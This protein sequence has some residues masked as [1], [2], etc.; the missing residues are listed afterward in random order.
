MRPQK[1][2]PICVEAHLGT[3]VAEVQSFGISSSYQG[4]LKREGGAGPAEGIYLHMG[5]RA[6]S[7]PSSRP[8]KTPYELRPYEDQLYLSK[9]DGLLLPVRVVERP[10]FYQ[11]STDDGIPYWKIALL[12][13]ENCLASTVFQMC[14]NWSAEKRCKFCGIELSLRKGLTIPQKTPD[15]LAQVARDASKLD[16]VTHVVLT[17]GTQ[18]HTKEEILHLSRCVSAIKGVVKLPIH[19]QC[20]PVERALLEVLKEAGAD[21]IGI[22]VESFD[23]KVLRRMAP[24]KASIGLS[25]FERS[26]K[27]AVEI[28]GPNQVS[29]F[30]ILGLGEK[31]TSVYRAVNLLGSMGVFPYLVPFRPIPGSILEAWPLPDAQ[32]CIEM[33]RMSAE[34]LSKKG[35]SSSQSLA[36][37]VRCG[38]CSGMKDFEEPKTDLTCRLTC[39]GKELQ[40][41]FK[42]REEVFVREQCMFKDTDRDDYDGQAHHLIVK[43]NGR[44]VGTVRIF[45]KDP[46]QRLWMGGR[47]AVL[48]E[49]RNMGVGEL[50]VKEAV[51][52][53]KL[54]GARRFL[55]YIQIQNVA[56][57]E[58]LGW[59]RVG[60]PFIHRDR[61]HQLMEAS[62]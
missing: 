50:L 61:P 10:K 33:Y 31:P 18:V 12:H 47:L 24:S 11:M 25:T 49:Y 2:N 48:K 27:E 26:W 1:S 38:A 56:F 22:H 8:F 19:V 16:D 32:Y 17:T 39:D 42:I 7:V 34:I 51:K 43:Q 46:G 37:C 30:I 5:H 44:I 13:G 41:A 59:K 58:S 9:K 57:F 54:R 53:A 14:A 36:G 4:I 6:V 23:E 52:E 40:E 60:T 62:L 35:L 45:E 20:E 28:F 29:S 3:V 55:A 15:Q 21:T